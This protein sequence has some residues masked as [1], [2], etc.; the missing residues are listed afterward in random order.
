MTILFAIIAM[1]AISLKLTLFVFI[2]IPISGLVISKIG[3]K[4]K[5]HSKNVQQEQGVFLSVLDETLHGLR[6]IK[7]YTA[8]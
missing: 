3:K 6:I 8:A 1:L 2:F 7:G 5:K 4:L